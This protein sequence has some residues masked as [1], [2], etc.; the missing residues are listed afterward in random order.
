MRYFVSLVY[1]VMP[2]LSLLI[3]LVIY[4]AKYLQL[5]TVSLVIC[6]QLTN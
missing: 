5:L 2:I 3:Y 1:V 6:S 4:F